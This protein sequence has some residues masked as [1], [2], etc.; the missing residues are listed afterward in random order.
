MKKF[1][2]MLAWSVSCLNAKVIRMDD[3][4]NAEQQVRQT[5]QDLLQ[6]IQQVFRTTGAGNIVASE[7]AQKYND[8]YLAMFNELDSNKQ[9][10]NQMPGF[11]VY[12]PSTTEE[13]AQVYIASK[14][15]TSILQTREKLQNLGQR[16]K[17][18]EVVN[19][20]TEGLYKYNNGS[21]TERQLL[22]EV[23]NKGINALK[24]IN[25][26]V[27]DASSD[28]KVIPDIDKSGT[29]VI[30]TT[31]SPCLV[32]TNDNYGFHCVNY[33]KE[34]RKNFPK[35]RFVICYHE[36]DK[37]KIVK[38][39]IFDSEKFNHVTFANLAYDKDFSD[40]NKDLSNAI[41]G[42][43]EKPVIDANDNK[44]IKEQINNNLSIVLE[45]LIGGDGQVKIYNLN[46]NKLDTIQLYP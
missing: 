2:L 16:K 6:A 25:K 21:H 45:Y 9:P 15:N 3:I 28:V 10:V 8:I 14:W 43:E 27:R 44:K 12:I 39:K 11:A 7:R 17:G 4:E 36:P 32:K 23:I 5:I 35:L 24:P 1:A 30:Y 46:E 22:S 33:Y 13:K 37:M 41:K 31:H 29:V 18:E 40:K 42:F 38:N 19:N 34:M 26:N 20:R